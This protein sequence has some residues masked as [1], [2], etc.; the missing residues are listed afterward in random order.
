MRNLTALPIFLIALLIAACNYSRSIKHDFLSG[1]TSTGKNIDCED[2]FVTVNGEKK[3][4]NSFIYGES[5]K[6]KFTDVTG[7][8]KIDDYV[9]PEMI[10]TVVNTSG[11]TILQSDDLISGHPE[12]FNYSSLE[13]HGEITA[14]APIK[15]KQEYKAIVKIKDKKGD[16]TLTA[17]YPFKVVANDKIKVELTDLTVDEVYLYSEGAEKVI[18]NNRINFDDNI[19]IVLEGLKGFKEI[20]GKVFPGLSIKAT[21]SEGNKILGNDDLFADYA[22]SGIYAP[23]LARRISPYFKIP[24]T[25]FSNPLH[26]EMTLWDRKSEAKVAIIT[27]MILE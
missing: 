24:E 4:G 10:I 20:D 6:I 12:G 19:H 23:D 18:T 9:F 13:L 25:D 15:S 21:D 27:D 17:V 2:I 14:A 26:F 16:G 22:E 11:D 3:S 7:F 8:T 1:I 5:F